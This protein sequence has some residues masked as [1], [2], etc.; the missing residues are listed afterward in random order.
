MTQSVQFYHSSSVEGSS[1][2]VLFSHV[3]GFLL[4]NAMFYVIHEQ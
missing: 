1:L 2:K 3:Y 4:K